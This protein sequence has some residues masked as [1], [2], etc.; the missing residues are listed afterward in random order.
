MLKALH[1]SPRDPPV[2]VLFV[3]PG[4]PDAS[5]LPAVGF[6]TALELHP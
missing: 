1:S 3:S 5:T 2:R 6:P 4:T